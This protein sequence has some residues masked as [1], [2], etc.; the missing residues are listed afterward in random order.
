MH[1]SLGI[2]GYNITLL[3]I[4]KALASIDSFY[5]S[6]K[7]NVVR[8]NNR[9]VLAIA[10][11]V[12]CNYAFDDDLNAAVNGYFRLGGANERGPSEQVIHI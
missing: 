7:L 1:S 8:Y 9:F 11:G 5:Y 2:C 6:S 3:L 4:T 10:G 12:S